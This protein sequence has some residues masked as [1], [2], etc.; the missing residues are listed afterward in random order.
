MVSLLGAALTRH[1]VCTVVMVVSFTEELHA[2]SVLW[3]IGTLHSYRES[4]NAADIVGFHT[5][6]LCQTQGSLS[7]M[8]E[9]FNNTA[10][11]IQV[12]L[13]MDVYVFYGMPLLQIFILYYYVFRQIT[14]K[15]M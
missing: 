9:E 4:H 14:Y 13:K 3:R 8:I 1:H 5:A 10:A 11:C 7:K 2:C 12:R 15:R 6:P